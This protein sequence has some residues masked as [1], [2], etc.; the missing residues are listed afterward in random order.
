MIWGPHPIYVLMLYLSFWRF[1]SKT[2]TKTLPLK[3]RNFPTRR[4]IYFPFCYFLQFF[5]FYDSFSKN[6]LFIRIIYIPHT[7]S[8]N[9]SFIANYLHEEIKKRTN[10]ISLRV[11]KF[12]RFE[13]FNFPTRREIPY[14]SVQLD[15]YRGSETGDL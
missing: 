15:C 5:N 4:E 13:I 1:M 2:K 7:F 14:A 8:S 11:G 9:Y 12:P 10:H 6:I 3:S